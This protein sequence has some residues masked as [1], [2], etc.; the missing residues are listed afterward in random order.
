MIKNVK[1][2]WKERKLGWTANLLGL[3]MIDWIKSAKNVKNHTLRSQINQL[4][5][6]KSQIKQ[7]NF[8]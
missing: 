6:S 3:K 7:L 4:K 1:N 2:A 5:F 8:V